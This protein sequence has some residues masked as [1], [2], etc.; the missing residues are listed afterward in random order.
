MKENFTMKGQKKEGQ[1]GRAKEGSF[2]K[3]R[4]KEESSKEKGKLTGG[5]T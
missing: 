5:R 4:P 3:R 1:Q 2:Y